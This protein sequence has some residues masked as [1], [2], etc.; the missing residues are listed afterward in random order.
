MQNTLSAPL[1]AIKVYEL[2]GITYVPHYRDRTLYVAPGYPSGEGNPKMTHCFK[3][4][5]L[6]AAGANA[7]T[8]MLWERPQLLRAG[9]INASNS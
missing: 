9:G 6:E 8:L 5:E 2:N 7:A 4:S 1:E 3:A